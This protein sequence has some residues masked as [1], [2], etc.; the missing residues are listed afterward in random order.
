LAREAGVRVVED[1]GSAADSETTRAPWV[2]LE[3]GPLPEVDLAALL[4]DRSAASQTLIALD[5]VEDPQNL[6]AIARVADASGVG[7]LVLT[8]RHAPPL[9]EAVSRASAGAIE[10]LPVC[11]VPN[12]VRALRTLKD[13]GFWVVG[14]DLEAETDLFSAPDAWLRP[15]RVLV[16][17]SEGAGLR[18][19]VTEAI[20]HR[21]RIP[22]SGRIASLN[23]STAAAVI[24]FELGRRDRAREARAESGA[25]EPTGERRG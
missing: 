10:W 9:S 11:R 13:R 1:P 25:S 4:S 20:D 3:A 5:G 14:A 21:V 22:M 18:R 23:V 7:G 19:S 12:L 16:M 17:G 24:L 6:G 8:H 2:R 15:P